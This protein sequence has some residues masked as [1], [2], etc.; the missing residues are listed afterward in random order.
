METLMVSFIVMIG[1][2]QLPLSDNYSMKTRQIPFLVLLLVTLLTVASGCA[3]FKKKC[4]CPGFG[5]KN[6]VRSQPVS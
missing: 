1:C 6:K 3:M 2:E 4:D 5:N